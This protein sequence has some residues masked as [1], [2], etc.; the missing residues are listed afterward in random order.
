MHVATYLVVLMP[1]SMS[2]PASPFCDSQLLEMN[3]VICGGAVQL[4]NAQAPFNSCSHQAF[5]CIQP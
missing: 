3:A 5:T 2:L 4:G 1:V